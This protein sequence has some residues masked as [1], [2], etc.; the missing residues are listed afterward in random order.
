MTKSSAN[1]PLPHIGHINALFAQSRRIHSSTDSTREWHW[2]QVPQPRRCGS[3]E[4]SIVA[5]RGPPN[6]ETTCT[7]P[8]EDLFRVRRR[9]RWV[10]GGWCRSDAEAVKKGHDHV[11][12]GDCGDLLHATPA[13]PT[14]QGIDLKDPSHQFDP[15]SP[16]LA[17]RRFG[18]LCSRVAGR[19]G[20]FRAFD[21][22]L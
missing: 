4:G 20:G 2:A 3:F 16:S 11:R 1:L 15:R 17:H 19:F 18:G 22:S 12:V 13:L 7:S 6:R 8:V 10:K 5:A 14:G 9:P 21:R